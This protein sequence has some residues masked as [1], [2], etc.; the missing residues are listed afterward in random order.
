VCARSLRHTKA[1]VPR[2]SI[3]IIEELSGEMNSHKSYHAYR[4]SLRSSNPP[5]VPYLGVYLTGK[6]E[7]GGEEEER[8]K[9]KDCVPYLGVYLT[10]KHE[11]GG[12]EEERRKKKEK[13]KKEE[14]EKQ[15]RKIESKDE[16]P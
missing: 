15:K 14:E 4:S 11:E 9:K 8:R 2:K 16:G 13:K 10:G 3:E 1:L 12:E 6:H 7:E 5:C